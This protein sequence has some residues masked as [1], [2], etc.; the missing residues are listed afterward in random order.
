MFRAQM[1]KK[2]HKTGHSKKSPT[3]NQLWITYSRDFPASRGLSRR[4][5]S[6][7]PLLAG[8]VEISLGSDSGH[9]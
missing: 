9:L 8:K 7:R 6:E 1:K 2:K 4:G 3:K 5:K